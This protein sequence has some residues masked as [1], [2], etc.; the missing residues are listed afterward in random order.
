MRDR[1][2]DRRG[3]AA[4]ALD[5]GGTRMPLGRAG[6]ELASTFEPLTAT[7][8]PTRDDGASAA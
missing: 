2:P 6:G 1:V 3:A 8:A 7:V 4:L 5:R